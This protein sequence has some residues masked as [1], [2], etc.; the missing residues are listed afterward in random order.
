MARLLLLLSNVQDLGLFAHDEHLLVLHALGG[1]HCVDDRL[2]KVLD[3]SF[4][5]LAPIL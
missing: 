3:L 1:V 5:P 2:D 4:W